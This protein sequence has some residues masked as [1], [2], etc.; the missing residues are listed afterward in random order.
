MVPVPTLGG[1]VS[2][3][4]PPGAKSGSRMRLKA[5]GLPGKP[6]GDQ[7]VVTRIVVPADV[8]ESAL[9]LL[10]QF[11]AEVADNPRGHFSSAT[12]V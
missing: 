3:T 7:I 6:A 5:R 2:M 8:P 10:K 4:I 12:T 1:E 11:D 9:A